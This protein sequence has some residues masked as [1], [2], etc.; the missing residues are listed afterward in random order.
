MRI[1]PLS[2]LPRGAGVIQRD[3]EEESQVGEVMRESAAT[4]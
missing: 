2:R 3:A 4:P 1:T